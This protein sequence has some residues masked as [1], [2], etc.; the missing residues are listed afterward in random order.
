MR[1]AHHAHHREVVR[2]EH[3]G[4]RER[5][6]QAPEQLEHAGLHRDVEPGGRLVQDHQAR[7]QGEDAREPDAALL[8]PGELVRIEVEVGVR[9]GRPRPGSRPPRASRSAR[10]SVVWISN[11]SWSRGRTFQRGIERGARILVD[12]LQ[13]LGHRAP[14]A[15]GQPPDLAAGEA[16]LARGRRVDAHHRLAEGGLSA[17]A[18]AHEAERLARAHLRAT[19]RRRRAASPTRRPKALRTGKWRA[20]STS[21]SSGAAV[22]LTCPLPRG[23]RPD[24]GSGRS[25]RPRDRAAAGRST[26]HSAVAWSQRGME[27]AARRRGDQA[28]HLAGDVANLAARARARWRAAAACR[29]ARGGRRRRRSAPPPSPGRRTS[30]RRGRRS[31]GGAQ[32]V[33]GEEHRH[34]ALLHQRA[35]QAEDLRLDRHVE[36]G[37]RLVRDDEIGLAA[38]APSRS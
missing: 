19:R 36:R 25:G 1:L 8:A 11:G 18:L 3:V 9:A 30:R 17:A 23:R 15:A 35:Q 26:R 13:I 10:V 4:E 37:G 28:R 16:D 2:D 32:I 34:A 38:A 21:S 33:G 6:L 14:R 31:R 27:A 7:P 24:G 5:L 29:D 20:R 22:A 12:V